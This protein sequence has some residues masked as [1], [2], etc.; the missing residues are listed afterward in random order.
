M[1]TDR[2]A[3]TSWAL[4]ASKVST[5]AVLQSMREVPT[6]APWRRTTR[7]LGE[8]SAP[9]GVRYASVV[10]LAMVWRP[11]ESRRVRLE[12]LSQAA[13]AAGMDAQAGAGALGEQEAGREAGERAGLTVMTRVEAETGATAAT[14]MQA[15]NNTT[16]VMRC[17][18]GGCA[19]Q[20]ESFECPSR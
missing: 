14:R 2:S 20:G 17:A 12:A 10:W 13:R 9:A 15:M 19:R 18:A 6:P 16:R 5:E 1:T 7:R 8:K 11:E 4:R 3:R